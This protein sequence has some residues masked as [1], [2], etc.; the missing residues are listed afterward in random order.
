[1]RVLGGRA[2]FAFEEMERNCRE[3]P[4]SLYAGGTV[5]IQKLL[6]ARRMG[7]A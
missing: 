6:I 7:L 4:F 2:H 1:M 5:E 3:A